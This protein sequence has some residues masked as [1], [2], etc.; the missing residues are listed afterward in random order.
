MASLYVNVALF[1]LKETLRTDGG[2]HRVHTYLTLQ[3][4]LTH[5]TLSLSFC[6]SLSL[7]YI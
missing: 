2:T 5:L 1:D 7:P 6:L 3:R 4:W